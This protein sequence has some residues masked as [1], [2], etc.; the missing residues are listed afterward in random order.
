MAVDVFGWSP[1]EAVLWIRQFVPGA[2]EN[3]TQF[4]F[5]MQSFQ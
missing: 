5:V 2:V 1:L 3:E 4:N